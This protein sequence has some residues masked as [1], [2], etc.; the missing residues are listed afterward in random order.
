MSE[1]KW[2]W[3]PVEPTPEMI[4]AGWIDKEDTNPDDIYRAMLAAAPKAVPAEPAESLLPHGYLLAKVA[5]VVPLLQEARDALT[6]ITEA[7]RVLHRISPTLADRMDVAGTYSLDDWREHHAGEQK[8]V[9]AADVQGMTD[10]VARLCN[11]VEELAEA[12]DNAASDI[13]GSRGQIE[14]LRDATESARAIAAL[15]SKGGRE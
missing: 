10:E 9:P 8:A 7:Q 15:Q 12:V 5:M 13:G 2:Q 11:L 6:A 3:V 14:I 4:E 1:T